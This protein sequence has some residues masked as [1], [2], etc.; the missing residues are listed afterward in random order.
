MAIEVDP[1]KGSVVLASFQSR[2]A[3]EHMLSSL[4]RGFRKEARRG[5]VTAF[6]VS[7]NKDGSL[8]LTQSRVLTAGGVG[9]ALIRIPFAWALGLM[10]LLS[11][12][13][14]AT[15]FGHAVHLHEAHVGSDE[16]TAHAILAR[17]GAHAAIALVSCKD[18]VLSRTV[19]QQAADQGSE[20]WEGSRTRFLAALDPGSYEWVRS[21]LGEPSKPAD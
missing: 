4:G 14:G 16:Q 5:Q 2:H 8:K 10:G 13:K 12:L 19:A 6:V 15:G 9:A 21:A 7:A 11:T 17:A 3:A 20:S 18:P 1:A